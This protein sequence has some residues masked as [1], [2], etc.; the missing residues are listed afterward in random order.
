MDK[1]LE[2]EFIDKVK[3]KE[4]IFTIDMIIHSFSCSFRTAQRRIKRLNAH[5]SYNCN[6]RYYTLPGIPKFDKNG[7]W[8]F[9]N[10]RFSKYGNLKSTVIRLVND[11]AFGF[12]YQ[13]LCELLGIAPNSLR[14]HFK[15]IPEIRHDKDGRQSVLF[16]ND[17]VL[18]QKQKEYR[19]VYLSSEERV[20][21]LETDE[22]IILVDRIKYPNAR[23]EDCAK[24]LCRQGRNIDVKMIYRLLSYHDLLKKLRI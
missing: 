18:Y 22:V 7:L 6:G 5:T 24:R 8:M 1:T 4:K 14:T 20:L 12:S 21:S 3:N 17:K 23:I 9:N 2:L 16:S 19:G 13:D 10:A 15:K 11:S